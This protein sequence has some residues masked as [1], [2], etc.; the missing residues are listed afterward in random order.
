VPDGTL[1][2]AKQGGFDAF[3]ALPPEEEEGVDTER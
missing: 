3:R 1:F 2:R